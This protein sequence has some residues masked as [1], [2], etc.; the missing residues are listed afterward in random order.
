MVVS[1][2]GFSSGMSP[3]SPSS[4]SRVNHP[5]SI[6]SLSAVREL[7][8]AHAMAPSH[9]RTVH[10]HYVKS[11]YYYSAAA[12]AAAA[13]AAESSATTTT[14]STTSTTTT[15]TTQNNSST[16]ANAANPSTLPQPFI[17]SF[18]NIPNLPERLYPLLAERFTPLTST[19]ATRQDS[20]D[21]STTKLGIR[22][23]DGAMIETVI[24]RYNKGES[25]RG[26]ARISV[27]L[28]SQIG[29][30]MACKFCATGTM[31]LLGNLTSGEIVEQLLH[32]VSVL[33]HEAQTTQSQSDASASGQPPA[34]ADDAHSIVSGGT[35][36]AAATYAHAKPRRYIDNV[37]FMGMGEPL[38]NYAAVVDAIKLMT[39]GQ[40]LRL[41]ASKICIS[42]VGVVPRIRQLATELPDVKLAL[43]L[44]APTQALR[45]RIV[46][47]ARAY[48]VERL[49]E[50]VDDAVLR[51]G[52]QLLV[53]Y[54]CIKGLNVTEEAAHA[55]GRLLAPRGPLVIL[56]LI[57][58]N[59]TEAG[60]LAVVSGD[61]SARSFGDG[62]D[63]DNEDGGRNDDADVRGFERPSEAELDAFE[64]VLS[65][66]YGVLTKVR[67]TMGSDIAGA[68]GQL[69]KQM[70]AA[71]SK[72][73]GSGGGRGAAVAR[74][75]AVDLEDLVVRKAKGAEDGPTAGGSAQAGGGLRRRRGEGGGGR[76]GGD[77][78]GEPPMPNGTSGGG[79][80]GGGSGGDRGKD[81]RRGSDD[82]DDDDGGGEYVEDGN[83]LVVRT[84]WG[85]ILFPFILLLV[86]MVLAI[87]VGLSA[88]YA[89][90]SI[91]AG[92]LLN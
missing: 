38:D 10:A 87:G 91:R 2:R 67:R 55:L 33:K 85:R 28:S 78:A 9:A 29:C 3:L 63:D 56:N 75:S 23:Q 72:G 51:R 44:H 26:R 45:V 36:A 84:D 18:T 60:D 22:L 37:V 25:R 79:G 20:E 71:E 82:E 32:V 58:Y 40:G 6:H 21:G 68:C 16:D 65:Q 13:A 81:G 80:G 7:L 48:T 89:V 47:T 43:S 42:T 41:D 8:D 30:K 66:E 54:I 1:A 12:A 15:T 34:D 49:M 46:P 70:E 90:R 4:S 69:V 17:P 92:G 86:M 62:D 24:M 83:D 35:A 11:L 61:P 39:D 27:C 73:R 31:G 5:A 77:S 88:L 52:K 50:A 53:E 74:P 19:I 59:P 64:R 14:M 76:R 57:P